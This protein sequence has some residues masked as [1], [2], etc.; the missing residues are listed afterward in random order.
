[1]RSCV[2][3]DVDVFP[4]MCGCVDVWMWVCVEC[5]ISF[6][7]I[8]SNQLMPPPLA[9]SSPPPPY[10][11]TILDD[12]DLWFMAQNAAGDQGLI[13][14]N[15]VEIVVDV[16]APAAPQPPPLEEEPWF[17][18]GLK[19]RQQAEQLLKAQCVALFF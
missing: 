16:P 14:S 10:Q 6:H 13:P 3:V 1:M 17:H 7:F 15:F 8:D 18:A 5:A 11:L 4:W 19:S 2:S 9:S 12:S